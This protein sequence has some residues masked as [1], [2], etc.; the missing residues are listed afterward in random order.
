MGGGGGG[1]GEANFEAFVP[2]PLPFSTRFIFEAIS[3][4]CP[5]NSD[6][7]RGKSNLIKAFMFSGC[8]HEIGSLIY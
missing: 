8:C 1:G 5:A 3:S 4:V 7:G 2:Q 6:G